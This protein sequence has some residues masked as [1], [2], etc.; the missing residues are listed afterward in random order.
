MQMHTRLMTGLLTSVLFISPVGLAAVPAKSTSRSYTVTIKGLEFNP[1]PLTVARGDT[2]VWRNMDI[3]PHTINGKSA[4][5]SKN[6]APGQTWHWVAKK[7]GHF[8]YACAYHP[9]M[10]GEVVVN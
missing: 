6:L 7:K 8:K 5:D 2:V 10:L 1:S 4:F 3:V 9:T